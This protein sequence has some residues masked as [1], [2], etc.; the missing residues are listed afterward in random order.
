M[1]GHLNAHALG[2]DGCSGDRD[3]DQQATVLSGA[4]IGRAAVDCGDGC[5]DGQTEPKSIVGRAVAEALEWL[6]DAVDIRWADQWTGVGHSQLGGVRRGPG[7]DPNVAASDV[8]ADRIVDQVADEV[9]GQHRIARNGG[10]LECGVHSAVAQAG[11]VEDVFGDR[12]QIGL[13][14]DGEPA[15]VARE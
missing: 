12:G 2:W 13:L 10:G 3:R 1:F 8:V 9:F 6:E 7:A 5:D 4:G 11:G 15:L 14:A